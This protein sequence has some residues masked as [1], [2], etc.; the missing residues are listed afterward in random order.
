MHNGGSHVRQRYRHLVRGLGRLQHGRLD[1]QPSRER[2][3][4]VDTVDRRLHRHD[5]RQHPHRRIPGPVPYHRPGRARGGWHHQP[6]GR[7]RLDELRF[8][9]HHRVGEPGVGL[10]HMD[11]DR[12][13]TDRVPCIPIDQRVGL[14]AGDPHG[15]ILHSG[16]RRLRLFR[17]NVP[18]ALV[19]QGRGADAIATRRFGSADPLVLGHVFPWTRGLESLLASSILSRSVFDSVPVTE[20]I[21]GSA[22]FLRSAADSVVFS[23][24]P[25]ATGLLS[26]AVADAFGISDSAAR[27]LGLSV[28]VSEA[29]YLFRQCLKS[30]ILL[31]P[32]NSV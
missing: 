30:I 7:Q 11:C 10:R 1:G 4:T 15:L 3:R 24:S 2:R 5:R 22:A 26:R 25:L 20:A 12:A 28:V 16:L 14:R 29:T 21:V 27:G 19:H 9:C 13:H 6:S 31:L 17:R 32:H 8:R 23:D 18:D